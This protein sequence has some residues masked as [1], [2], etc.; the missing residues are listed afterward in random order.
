VLQE[1]AQ[2]FYCL[3]LSATPNATTLVLLTYAL[4]Q[5]DPLSQLPLAAPSARL[6]QWIR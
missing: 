4:A 2:I 6:Q 3:S 5:A 1:T